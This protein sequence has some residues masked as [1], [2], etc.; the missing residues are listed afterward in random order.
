MNSFKSITAG[1]PHRP[2]EVAAS[3]LPS[4]VKHFPQKFAWF[5]QAGYI[6]HEWQAAFHAAENS[7]TLKRFRHLVAGRRGGKTL[8]AAW[9]VVFYCLHPEVFH[10]DAHG[11]VSNRPLWVWVLAKDHEIGFPSRMAILNDVLDRLVRAGIITDKDFRYN[12]TNKH[13]EFANGTLLQFKSADD[14]QMLRGAGL[15]ILWIDEAAMIPSN[16][17]WGVVRP[18][19]SDKLGLTITTTTPRGK[20]WLYEEFWSD[21]AIADSSQF[22]VEYT[23]IDNPHFYK[24]EWEYAR[25]HM[26]PIL[27]KQEYMAAFD[28]MSGVELPGDWL[29]YWSEQGDNDSIALPKI[30]G[31]KGMPGVT[32]KGAKYMG[33][34]PAS[35]L[36]DRADHFAMCLIGVAEDRSQ[37][38]ILD[39]YK[40]RLAFPDQLDMI[41]QW[42]QMY[43]P[44][45]IG[46]ESNA[47]QRVLA[48]Q[49]ARLQGLPP[50]VPVMSKGKKE[51]RIMSMSPIFKIGKVRINANA[52]DF[53]EEWVG[54]DSTVRNPKDDL[55]D[56]TEIALSAANV[57]L[58]VRVTTQPKRAKTIDEEAWAQIMAKKKKNN[59]TDPELGSMA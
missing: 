55:L 9:E 35:S 8:S 16:E 27:F 30:E 34:D 41:Q 47:Y 29:H 11:T 5:L 14:P 25:T 36:S 17:A 21:E 52:R 38:F 57:L 45:Y 7:T 18:A 13:I 51:E 44:Q 49:A 1:G 43:R 40:G 46:I 24:E 10:Q 20:N 54:Y 37:A 23:S 48:Q 42:F 4:F 22:R 32:F 53:I 31:L 58:P 12:K 2:T 28:A 26:H 15:D 19:L 3:V 33:V 59:Y 56:A 39:T 6:P 50:V